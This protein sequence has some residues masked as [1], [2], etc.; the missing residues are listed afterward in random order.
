MYHL[1]KKKREICSVLFFLAAVKESQTLK[2]VLY[3]LFF[4]EIYFCFREKSIFISVCV[5]VDISF[6]FVLGFLLL[7]HTVEALS[8]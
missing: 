6:H 8:T 5:R 3:F 4:I 2:N 1:S 7:F